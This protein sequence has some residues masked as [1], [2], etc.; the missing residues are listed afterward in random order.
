MFVIRLFDLLLWS[1]VKRESQLKLRLG[2]RFEGIPLWRLPVV[3]QCIEWFSCVLSVRETPAR[4]SQNLLIEIEKGDA[5]P[6]WYRKWRFAS[7]DSHVSVASAGSIGNRRNAPIDDEQM[8][9]WRRSQMR[10]CQLRVIESR[11][12]GCTTNKLFSNKPNEP[13]SKS[14]DLKMFVETTASEWYQT[15]DLVV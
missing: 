3:L 10:R 4:S 14:P 6:E 1:S 7:G 15:R 2:T 13:L 9:R 11:L 12:D 5:A 8:M